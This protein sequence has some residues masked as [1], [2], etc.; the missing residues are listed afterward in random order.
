VRAAL[1]ASDI[2]TRS[3]TSLMMRWGGLRFTVRVLSA[4]QQFVTAMSYDDL[5]RVIGD[6]EL[7][8]GAE[9]TAV[10][11]EAHRLTRGGAGGPGDRTH[12]GPA[13]GLCLRCGRAVG[14]QRA[15]R[16]FTPRGQ[17]FYVLTAIVMTRSVS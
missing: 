2:H 6:P 8:A 13:H 15:D 12:P 16:D 17:S 1:N 14:V 9:Q 7:R 10:A 11:D 5:G 4:T 3:H